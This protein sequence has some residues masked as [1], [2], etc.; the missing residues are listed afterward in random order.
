M[1]LVD[2]LVASGLVGGH[3]TLVA[4][5]AIMQGAVRV[6]GVVVVRDVR[7]VLE[8]GLHTLMLK[9]RE[10]TVEVSIGQSIGHGA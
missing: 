7:H 5:R 8:A 6:N 4:R 2:A 10:A 1:T 9:G 3:G